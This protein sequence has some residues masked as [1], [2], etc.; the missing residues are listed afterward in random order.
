M[1]RVY[2]V[3]GIAMT[4]PFSIIKTEDTIAYSIQ[5]VLKQYHILDEIQHI[6]HVCHLYEEDIGISNIV[7]GLRYY[8]IEAKEV[9]SETIRPGIIC[10][11]GEIPYLFVCKK[12][13]KQYVIAHPIDGICKKTRQEI[14]AIY[15]G[16]YLQIQHIGRLKNNVSYMSFFQHIGKFVR[17]E[18]KILLKNLTYTT[19][20]I[21][22]C[23]LQSIV[24]L[25]MTNDVYTFPIGIVCVLGT[26]R[27]FFQYQRN[28]EMTLLAASFFQKHIHEKIVSANRQIRYTVRAEEIDTIGKETWRWLQLLSKEIWLSIVI[29]IAFCWQYQLVGLLFYLTMTSIVIIV[30]VCKQRVSIPST[31]DNKI[32]SLWNDY[33]QKGAEI[34]AF[35]YEKAFTMHITNDWYRF[36]K[37]DKKQERKQWRYLYGC[38]LGI[39]FLVCSSLWLF[40]TIRPVRIANGLC[41][42]LWSGM[43]CSCAMEIQKMIL[44]RKENAYAF[45]HYKE[46]EKQFLMVPQE[47]QKIKYIE[48]QYV[49]S[50][51]LSFLNV[52]FH[53][54]VQLQ[55]EV[56][57]I[58]DV[59]ALLTN[60]KVMRKGKILSDG[61]PWKLGESKTIHLTAE[62]WMEDTMIKMLFQHKKDR[63]ERIYFLLETFQMKELIFILQQKQEIILTKTQKQILMLVFAILERPHVLLLNNALSVVENRIYERVMQYL[64]LFLTDT[65]ILVYDSAQRHVPIYYQKI[66]LVEGRTN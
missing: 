54:G 1:D 53:H 41:V 63:Q 64:S 7:W 60:K 35:G 28:Q 33:L 22:F 29:G 27:C 59:F 17:R 4:Y 24:L 38:H 62:P 46:V 16:C 42:L 14:E 52:V 20:E 44:L 47:K 58:Q 48:F 37:E 11:K 9:F 57:A 43:Q 26:I 10:C 34:E 36:Q 30:I 50:Q 15:Q 25:K 65:I 49:C 32:L 21:V 3:G 66:V 19:I 51:S 13:K 40:F 55:G 31:R 45:V 18:R 5:R 61:Y 23:I 8:A 2:I 39:L 6:K 12:Y 56:A